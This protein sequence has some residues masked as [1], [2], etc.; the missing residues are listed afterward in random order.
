MGGRYCLAGI[1]YTKEPTMPGNS[2]ATGRWIIG[3]VI[4]HMYARG[5]IGVGRGI[6]GIV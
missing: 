5:R 3:L 6:D 4:G 1:G 2:I